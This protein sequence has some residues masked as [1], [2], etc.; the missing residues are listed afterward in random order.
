MG[1]RTTSCRPWAVGRGPENGISPDATA[2]CQLPT[3]NPPRSTAYGL[4]PT[5]H[6]QEGFTLAALIVILTIISV[7]IAMTV[8][9]QWSMIM[10]RERD[11]QTIFAM[12]Q[13]AR[14]IRSWQRKNSA[15][16]TS[17]DQLKEAK[18]PRMLRMR[19][20]EFPMPLT[21]NEKDWILVPLGALEAQQPLPQAPQ[22]QPN[23]QN[24]QNPQQPGLTPPSK[25]N[26]EASPKDYVGPFVGVRPNKEGKSFIALNGAE[27]YSEWVYTTQDLENEIQMRIA[28]IN[29]K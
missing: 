13:A 22:N 7:I 9:E 18:Q 6:G 28:A 4:R 12:K 3:A 16:P 19:G 11:Q 25:L 5:A 26:K 21:G 10:Q 27:D 23:P 24:P 29:I 20:D 8:P 1:F 17:L 2:N 14:A 15:L